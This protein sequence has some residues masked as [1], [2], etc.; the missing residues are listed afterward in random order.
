MIKD[1]SFP[2]NPEEALVKGFEAAERVYIENAQ[3]NGEVIEKSG[4]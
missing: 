3:E 2:N 4:S 1:P